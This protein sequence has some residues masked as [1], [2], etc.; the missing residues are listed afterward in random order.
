MILY[1]RATQI[2]SPFQGSG[3]HLFSD[4]NHITLSGLKAGTTD[5]D[6]RK[7]TYFEISKP[8]TDGSVIEKQKI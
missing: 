3:T 5:T 8:G 7:S 1:L 4:Y 2:I 6:Q